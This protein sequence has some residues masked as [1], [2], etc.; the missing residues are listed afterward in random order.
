MKAV[1][2]KNQE[3]ALKLLDHIVELAPDF[4]EA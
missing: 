1:T 2:E 3:L 4:T